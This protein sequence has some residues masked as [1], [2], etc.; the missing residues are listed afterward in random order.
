MTSEFQ[1]E[2]KELGNHP[3]NQKLEK[4]EQKIEGNRNLR[5]AC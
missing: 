1:K 2:S 3:D 4:P 5:D